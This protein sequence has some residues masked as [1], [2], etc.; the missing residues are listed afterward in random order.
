MPQCLVDVRVAILSGG[1]KQGGISLKGSLES[2]VQEIVH[3]IVQMSILAL[4]KYLVTVTT[5]SAISESEASMG[6][7]VN[8][9]GGR[10]GRNN[11]FI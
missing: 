3:N 11:G 2:S 4:E 9:G 5:C 7:N 6:D 1:Q 10:R 8:E